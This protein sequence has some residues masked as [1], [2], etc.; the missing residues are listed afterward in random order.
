MTDQPPAISGRH[1][2]VVGGSI[3]GLLAGRVLA[4]HFEQ[5][6]IIERDVYPDHPT[7]RRGVPQ[8]RHLHGLLARGKQI[9]EA[10]F[11]GLDAELAAAGCPAGDAASD[12]VTSLP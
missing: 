4:D 12:T 9:M 2:I 11:P 3:T 1:A 10:L 6:S 8:A 7:F 5:V